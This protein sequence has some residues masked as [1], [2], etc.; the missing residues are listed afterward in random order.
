MLT[1]DDQV[2]VVDFGL[3]TALGTDDSS[4]TANSPTLTF[5]ATQDGVIQGTAAYMS[6]EQT[7]GS[8][9]RQAQRRVGFRLRVLTRR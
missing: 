5:E 7:Q 6:P 1:V 2:K 9:R 8:G 3:A 4:K